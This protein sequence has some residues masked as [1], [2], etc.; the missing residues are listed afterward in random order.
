[1]ELPSF[2]DLP[3]DSF[4]RVLALLSV[5]RSMPDHLI[6]RLDL[7]QMMSLITKLASTLLPL[8]FLW[9]LKAPLSSAVDEWSRLFAF[10][11]VIK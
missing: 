1:M 10:F 8:G 7:S 6:W 3:F 4:Q 5:T 11:S 2:H 9:L